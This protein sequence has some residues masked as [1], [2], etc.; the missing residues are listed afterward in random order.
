[1]LGIGTCENCKLTTVYFLI[2]QCVSIV[3]SYYFTIGMKI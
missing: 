1:M 2:D 3:F